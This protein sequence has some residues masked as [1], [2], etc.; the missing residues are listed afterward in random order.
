MRSF[1][2]FSPRFIVPLDLDIRALMTDTT[3]IR[4]GAIPYGVFGLI[5]STALIIAGAGILL[6]A[7]IIGADIVGGKFF[8][9]AMDR[10]SA[11][12]LKLLANAPV[13]LQ[14]YFYI[15]LIVVFLLVLPPL[16]LAA[17]IRGGTGWRDLLALRS[18]LRELDR[19]WL[20]IF[21]A[22]T[23]V[24][25]LGTGLLVKALFPEFKTWFFVPSELQ[26]LVLSIIGVIIVAPVVEELLFRGWIYSSL[27]TSFRASTAIVITTVLFAAVHSDGGLIYPALVLVPGVMLALVREWTGSVQV[28][29][30]AHAMFN[31]WAWL[32]QLI[33]GDRI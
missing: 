5:V 23:P 20:M 18:S 29:I 7:V 1:A 6:I 11:Y 15:V 3:G 9:S 8:Q 16:L 17:R 33:I 28:C 14:R 22:A 26:G 4:S 19:K 13:T 31:A 24:Y 10:L 12:D 25:I 21:V 30:A 2:G 27:R 32:L